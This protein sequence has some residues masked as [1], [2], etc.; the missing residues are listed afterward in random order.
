MNPWASHPSRRR[1]RLYIMAEILEIARDRTLKTPI[2]YKANLSFTQVN[3]YLRLMIEINLVKKIKQ[4]DRNIYAATGK[5]LDFLQRYRELAEL[6]R[7]EEKDCK[8]N[9]KVPP[10]HMLKNV[11]SFV[12]ISKIAKP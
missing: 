8:I 11:K 7:T 10:S 1:D 3:E 4:N 2:M 6:L 9:V 12:Y 5:G